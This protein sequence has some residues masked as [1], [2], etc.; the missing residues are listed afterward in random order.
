M[1]HQFPY[2]ECWDMIEALDTSLGNSESKLTPTEIQTIGRE[3]S[4]I[5]HKFMSRAVIA[6]QK[7]MPAAVDLKP[8]KVSSCIP[9]RGDVASLVVK[10][11]RPGERGTLWFRAPHFGQLSD[12][13][14]SVASA[15]SNSGDVYVDDLNLEI[16]GPTTRIFLNHTPRRFRYDKFEVV[17]EG[18]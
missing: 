15:F 5:H 16:R 17:T 8:W 3:L 7:S 14:R 10:L 13:Y 2:A 4:H 18:S 9:S 12:L 1:N 6:A 11:D